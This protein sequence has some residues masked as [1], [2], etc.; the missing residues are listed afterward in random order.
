MV[1]HFSGTFLAKHCTEIQLFEMHSTL[2]C[3]IDAQWSEIKNSIQK[4]CGFYEDFAWILRCQNPI[5]VCFKKTDTLYVGLTYIKCVPFFETDVIWDT[6]QTV[7]LHWRTLIHSES[8]LENLWPH[9]CYSELSN[10]HAA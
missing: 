8:L 2:L 4:L 7:L 9:L 6:F 1:P 10:K 5:K 3:C